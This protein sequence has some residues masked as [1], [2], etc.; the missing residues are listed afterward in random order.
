M[1]VDTICETI[2][3]CQITKQIAHLLLKLGACIIPR[4]FRCVLFGVLRIPL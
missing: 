3:V 2:L 1:F 4:H